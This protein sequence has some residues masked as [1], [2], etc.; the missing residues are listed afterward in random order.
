MKKLLAALICSAF[1]TVAFAQDKMT[2]DEKKK[3]EATKPYGNT[4]TENKAPAMKD[5]APAAAPM[6][7]A[8]P[9]KKDAPVAKGMKDGKPMMTKEEKKK[10]RAEK[11]KMR[12]DKQ[13]EEIKQDIKKP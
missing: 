9:M 4:P 7:D 13:K 5:A 6:K 1:A 2:T 3:A 12:A 10:M 11:N 8:A